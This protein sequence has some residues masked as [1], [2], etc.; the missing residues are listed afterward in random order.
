MLEC[1]LNLKQIQTFKLWM[2]FEFKANSNFQVWIYFEFKANSNFQKFEF[3]FNSKYIQ[4]W[5]F[6]FA[7]NSKKIPTCKF[8]STLNLK[9]LQT[10]KFEFTLDLLQLYFEFSLE[11]IT[12]LIFLL[13]INLPLS[14]ISHGIVQT[15]ALWWN[16]LPCTWLYNVLCLPKFKPTKI[17]N[18]NI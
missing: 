3:T 1:T 10:C 2:F 12:H 17:K 8:E 16:F 6:E 9:K 15:I 13:L 14:S 5:K 11:P 4:T 18:K 7:S